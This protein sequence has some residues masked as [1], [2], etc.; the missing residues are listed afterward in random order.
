[1]PFIVFLN[2]ESCMTFRYSPLSYLILSALIAQNTLAQTQS[3]IVE[4]E[5]IEVVAEVHSHNNN[6]QQLSEAEIQRTPKTNGTINGLLRKNGAVHYSNHQNQSTQGGE[7]APELVSFHGEPY[8]NNLFLIDGLSNN[9]IINPGYSNGGFNSVE[10]SFEQGANLYLAPSAPES[11]QVDSSLLRKVSVYDSNIPAKYSQF[12]GG[13]VDAELKEADTQKASGRISYRTTRDRWTYFHFN[14]EEAEQIAYND[15]LNNI[16]PEFTKHIYN[17]TANQPLSERTA[18][19]F[20]YNRTQS[21]IP[22]NHWLLG[23]RVEEKRLAETYLLKATHNA[24]DNHKLNASLLYSPHKNVYFADNVKNGRYTTSGGGYRAT[25]VS[26]LFVDDFGEIKTSLDFSAQ[27]NQVKYDTAD[28][29]Y[30]WIGNMPQTALDW[31]SGVLSKNGYAYCSFAR[32]GGLGELE[33]ETKTW[34]LKQ[35]YE[36]LPI[37]SRFGTHQIDF[38]WAAS[39]A[40]ARSMRPRDAHFYYNTDLRAGISRAMWESGNIIVPSDC[41]HCI[42]NE[43]FQTMWIRYPQYQGK[44]QVNNYTLYAD[45]EWTFGK[46]TL[47]PGLNLSYDS[48]LKNLNLAPRFMFNWALLD[49]QKLTLSGGLNRYYAGNILANALRA[50]IP[51]DELYYRRDASG[52]FSLLDYHRWVRYDNVRHL[53]TPYSDELNLGFST[54][55]F[56]QLFSAKYVYRHGQQQFVSYK[57]GSVVTLPNGKS[58]QA[59]VMDNSGENRSNSVTFVLRNVEPM[60]VGL[61]SLGYQFGLNIQK[62]KSNSLTGYL[63]ANEVGESSVS[64]DSQTRGRYYI[65]NEQSYDDFYA[66]KDVLPSLNFNARWNAFLEINTD[67]PKYRFKWTHYLNYRPGYTGYGF[68]QGVCGE[69]IFSQGCRAEGDKVS[70]FQTTKHKKALTLDWSFLYEIPL[71]KGTNLAL[72]LDVI[73]VFNAKVATSGSNTKLLATSSSGENTSYQLGRQ[74]WFGVAYNW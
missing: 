72:N 71:P 57:D 47:Q 4:L 60:R 25:L 68:K 32:E 26:D 45:D 51:S 44:A 70:I 46:W 61:L 59:T 31:C 69:T 3:D 17:L 18:L 41:S 64:D 55:L 73:N 49:E 20:A 48:Y 23:Q 63:N 1:M 2:D 15:A 35:D 62:A 19:L 10:K 9:D 40:K 39:F 6:P 21:F 5:E 53:K 12:T 27:R 14:P 11:F 67:L 8:Y 42:P 29:R 34:T 74:Y 24:T 30:V 58:V 65:Y 52:A 38:G 66:M 37:E 43:Q 7:I 36:L 33:S 13:V 22:E 28:P 54:Q 56:N 50:D 16:Q